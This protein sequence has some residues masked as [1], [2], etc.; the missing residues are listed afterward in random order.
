MSSLSEQFAKDLSHKVFAKIDFETA[1]IYLWK[2]K[3]NTFSPNKKYKNQV[4]GISKEQKKVILHNM[5]QFLKDFQRMISKG[6]TFRNDSQN[7]TYMSAR[8]YQI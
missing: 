8:K 6:A 7:I 2:I 3:N 1:K 4:S 5:Q